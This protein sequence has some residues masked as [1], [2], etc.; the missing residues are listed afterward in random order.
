[1]TE[2]TRAY[3]DRM[4]A[5]LHEVSTDE[6][7]NAAALLWDN[8][9][10]GRRVIFCGND[11]VEDRLSTLARFLHCNNVSSP[12]APPGKGSLRGAS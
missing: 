12:R 8:Y 4:V 5:L 6:I 9:Q 3:L 11:D 2:Y 10:G 7:D 1:M